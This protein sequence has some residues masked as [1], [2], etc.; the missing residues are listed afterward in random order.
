MFDLVGMLCRHAL[1]VMIREDFLKIPS[2]N[3]LKRWTIWATGSYPAGMDM[4]DNGPHTDDCSYLKNL[5]HIA[6]EDL[7]KASS[8]DK[9]SLEAAVEGMGKLTAAIRK[10]TSITETNH[11][12]EPP[13]VESFVNIHVNTVLA[14]ERVKKSGKP[15][16]VRPK[17][18]MD[19]AAASAKKKNKS[20]KT[21]KKNPCG[22]LKPRERAL[23]SLYDNDQTTDTPSKELE[24]EVS[25]NIPSKKRKVICSTCHEPGH[26]RLKCT[27]R[28]IAQNLFECLQL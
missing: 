10:N 25:P 4:S 26:T 6:A 15:A 11:L 1:K 13:H 23:S 22:D 27:R 5:L 19:Y 2:R 12:L 21:A 16:S 14:P 28:G 18:K 9:K 24:D 3:I 20:N 8:H 17:S 7:M